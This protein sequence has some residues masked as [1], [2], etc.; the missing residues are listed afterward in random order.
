LRT[1]AAAFLAA[2]LAAPSLA[3]PVQTRGELPAFSQAL[4]PYL[5]LSALLGMRYLWCPSIRRETIEYLYVANARAIAV[6]TDDYGL[7]VQAT[8]SSFDRHKAIKGFAGTGSGDVNAEPIFNFNRL[9]ALGYASLGEGTRLSGEFG[10]FG[11]DLPT[12]QLPM[13][14][15]QV[16]TIS[17]GHLKLETGPWTFSGTVANMRAD[18]TQDVD[19]RFDGVRERYNYLDFN[20]QRRSWIGLTRLGT[21]GNDAARKGF[22]SQNESFFAHQETALFGGRLI[23]RLDAYYLPATDEFAD[24]MTSVEGFVLDKRLSI[25]PGFI[26]TNRN[27]KIVHLPNSNYFTPGIDSNYLALNLEYY[28]RPGASLYAALTTGAKRFIAQQET[29]FEGGFLLRFWS[30]PYLP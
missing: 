2:V 16:G 20:V 5:H 30:I 11:I 10:D 8:F 7:A 24:V 22:T 9:Y 21:I 29:R 4:A 14:L 13:D 3:A 28:P 12:I 27:P 17:G 15:L 25:R 1:L 26:H 23:P 18:K 19:Y 6:K